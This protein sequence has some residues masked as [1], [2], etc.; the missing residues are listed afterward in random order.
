MIRKQVLTNFS[1]FDS[2]KVGTVEEFQGQ[3]RKIILVS[4]VRTNPKMYTYDE[5]NNIGF[6]TNEKRLN[7]AITRA[8]SL[9]VIFG[10]EQA[11]QNHEK[12]NLIADYAKK[13][14][15]FFRSAND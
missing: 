9:L 14:G 11:I 1:K 13:N 15:T 12:W 6:M 4:L 2:V 5:K 7:V 10:K 8:K 3:E